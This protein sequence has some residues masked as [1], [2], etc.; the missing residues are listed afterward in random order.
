M[1]KQIITVKGTF[2]HK[3]SA[4]YEELLRSGG[5]V[6]DSIILKDTGAF[7]E[8]SVNGDVIGNVATED[9]ELPK[10]YTA[11]LKG[12]GTEPKSFLVEVETSEGSAAPSERREREDSHYRLR[13]MAY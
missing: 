10:L 9:F 6:E 8:A 3:D 12:L 4:K 5:A 2:L 13:R 7:I 11:T 1:N